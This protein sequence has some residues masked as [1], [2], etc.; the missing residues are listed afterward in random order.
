MTIGNNKEKDKFMLVIWMPDQDN[1]ILTSENENYLF[2]DL[3][4][5][6]KIEIKAEQ[7]MAGDE[8]D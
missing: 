4:D 6:L 5:H 3:M 2:A 8:E 7:K 1:D